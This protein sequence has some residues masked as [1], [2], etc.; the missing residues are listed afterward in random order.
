[1]AGHGGGDMIDAFLQAQRFVIGGQLVGQ[2]LNQAAHIAIA[3]HGGHGAHQ[4]GGGAE[5]FQLQPEG[6]EF[7]R[8][9]FQPV[10]AG[11][12]DLHH[13]GHQQALGGHIAGACLRA[14]PLEHQPFMG[15][16]LIHDD[17]PVLR[18]GHDIGFGDLTPR[19][20]ERMGGGFRNR[21]GGRLGAAQGRREGRGGFA[22]AA[23]FSVVGSGG[24][25][26]VALPGQGF[27]ACGQPRPWPF[28]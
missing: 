6:A 16:M 19:H 8:A 22:Q 2:I 1:M 18:F 4:H 7:V 24:V 26:S 5:A 10:A 23:G 27:Q 17:Q 25:G 12:L 21:F 11:F 9:R 15:G 28:H 13:F 20:A 3:Q 14:H